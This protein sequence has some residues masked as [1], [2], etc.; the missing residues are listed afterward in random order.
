MNK[1]ETLSLDFHVALAP[2]VNLGYASTM[3]AIRATLTFH[4]GRVVSVI[5]QLLWD[6]EIVR[7]QLLNAEK[8]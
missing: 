8:E 4:A 7:T 5:R 3:P 2:I 6:L 1:K